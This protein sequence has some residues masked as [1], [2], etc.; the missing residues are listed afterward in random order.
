MF[1]GLLQSFKYT[2]LCNEAKPWSGSSSLPREREREKTNINKARKTSIPLS[3]L[4]DP[5]LSAPLL[6]G[7]TARHLPAFKCAAGPLNPLHYNSWS[8]QLAIKKNE[9]ER[10]KHIV[11]SKH[12]PRHTDMLALS[13]T[14]TDIWGGVGHCGGFS[15]Q[16]KWAGRKAEEVSSQTGSDHSARQCIPI[17][18]YLLLFGFGN[19]VECKFFKRT[20]KERDWARECS[21]RS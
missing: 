4:L 13:P 6:S 9:K 11:S 3:D 1:L 15:S 7:L 16:Q 12:K 20:E 21:L 17:E 18:F 14:L 2:H 5:P 10:E 19:S 8:E